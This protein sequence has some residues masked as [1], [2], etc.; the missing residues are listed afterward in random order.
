MLYHSF[1]E[2]FSP[3]IQPEP[4][5]VEPEGVS[6]CPII[7]YMGEEVERPPGFSLLSGSCGEREGP[8]LL[9]EKGR[10]L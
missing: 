2:F 8:E 4:P 9:P 7:F 6:S 1:S 10:C 3:D 5:L